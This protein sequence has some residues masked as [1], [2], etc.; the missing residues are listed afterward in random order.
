L[1]RWSAG[2]PYERVLVHG[3]E[4]AFCDSSGL[5]FLLRLPA[6][7]RARGGVHMLS[8]SAQL[9]RAVEIAGLRSVLP[10]HLEAARHLARN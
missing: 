1:E 3:R 8:E 4:L 2:G 6:R 5:Q 7:L 9:R 10:L